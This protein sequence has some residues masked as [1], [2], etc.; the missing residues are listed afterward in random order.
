QAS[1]RPPLASKSVCKILKQSIEGCRDSVQSAEQ[2]HLPLEESGFNGARGAD[3][4]LPRRISRPTKSGQYVA[5]ADVHFRLRSVG[6]PGCSI[7][8]LGFGAKLHQQ[9]LVVC[10]GAAERL[11]GIFPV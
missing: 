7:T 8:G 11:K 10:I 5:R 2:E 1:L 9:V 4:T 3:Q 6:N